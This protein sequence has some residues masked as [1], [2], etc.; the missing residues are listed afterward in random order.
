MVRSVEIYSHLALEKRQW[1][2]RSQF[3]GEEDLEVLLQQL[4]C[5]DVPPPELHADFQTNLA[6]KFAEIHPWLQESR[7]TS[8]TTEAPKMLQ[9]EKKVIVVSPLRLLTIAN[10]YRCCNRKCTFRLGRQVGLEAVGEF[11]CQAG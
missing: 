3:L 6:R 2:A 5:G 7:G 10:G 11:V 1:F 4:V 8:L 9:N